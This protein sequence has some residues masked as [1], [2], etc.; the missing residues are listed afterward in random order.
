MA[1]ADVNA[2]EHMWKIYNELENRDTVA[3]VDCH[4]ENVFRKLLKF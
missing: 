3:I 2:C 4:L 1:T